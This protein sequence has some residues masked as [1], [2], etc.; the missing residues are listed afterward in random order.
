MIEYFKAYLYKR[1]LPSTQEDVYVLS[2]R[3]NR[4]ISFGSS[5]VSGA[6]YSEFTPGATKIAS[7][8]TRTI[9]FNDMN[10]EMAKQYMEH[11]DG[12]VFYLGVPSDDTSD[13]SILAPSE[14]NAIQDSS[15]DDVFEQE[16]AQ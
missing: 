5:V 10:D 4:G 13:V 7:G 3:K 15:D 12:N 2:T 6:S 16:Q 1:T 11:A 14:Y 8:K 9:W